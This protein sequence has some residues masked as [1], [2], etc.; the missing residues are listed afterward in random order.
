L[1]YLTNKFIAG[2]LVFLVAFLA[3][4]SKVAGAPYALGADGYVYLKQLD[5]FLTSGHFH[6]FDPSLIYA[7]F[8]FIQFIFRDLLT[9]YQILLVVIYA[10]TITAYFYWAWAV[11]KK[12]GAG[13]L[14]ALVGLASSTLI[15]V[16]TQ[17]PKNALGG[18]FLLVYFI[19][20]Y[21][22]KMLPALLS[23]VFAVCTHRLSAGLFVISLLIK[24]LFKSLSW[25]WILAVALG[26]SGSVLLG[27]F[28]FL[29][30]QRFAGFLQ[31]FP[32]F[33]SGSFMAVLGAN[34]ISFF[35]KTELILFYAM[36]LVGIWQYKNIKLESF[37]RLM[38]IL[39]MLLWPW[40]VINGNSMGFRLFLMAQLLIPM[41]IP[42]MFDRFK[43]WHRLVRYGICTGLVLVSLINFSTLK[44][45]T[46]DPPYAYYHRLAL[47]LE[48]QINWN[49]TNLLIVHKPLSDYLSYY[50][51]KDTLA[52]LA[53][54]GYDLKRVCRL[55]YDIPEFTLRSFFQ[56][57]PQ[58]QIHSMGTRY[59]LMRE[60]DYQEFLAFAQK[61]NDSELQQ[62]IDS[63]NN[64]NLPRPAF[65]QRLRL[66]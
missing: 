65:L 7:L 14:L 64:P 22:Q 32:Q 66:K 34:K 39:L 27:F 51:K 59:V 57:N 58:V 63:P 23:G 4:F 2:L 8:L 52:W 40:Y 43:S 13:V 50:F 41:L 49:E 44:I 10:A 28:H 45:D 62:Q 30:L 15:Y 48:K 5:T 36:L 9:S 47:Q 37:R 55:V 21:H 3:F 31:I 54:D 29:D 53:P 17:F 25:Y 18:F 12:I 42:F 6:F 60:A 61:S 38:L 26:L 33:V 1:P 11:T 24:T 35:W 46:F 19:F 20:E 16:V 56:K